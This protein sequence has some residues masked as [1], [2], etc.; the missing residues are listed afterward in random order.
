MRSLP[1][2]RVP[3]LLVLIACGAGPRELPVSPSP[4]LETCCVRSSAGDGLLIQYLGVGGWLFRFGEASLLTAPL[5]SNPGLL[6]VG[7]GRIATDTALVD[8][9]LPPVRD[10]SAILVGHAHYDHLMDVPYIARVKAPGAVV[11]GSRTA[12]NLLQGD[13]ELDPARLVDVESVAG[14]HERP[15]EWIHVADDRIRVMALRSEHAPHFLGLLLFGGEVTEPAQ[16]LPERASGWLAG[17]PLSYLIDFLDPD[18]RVV[19]RIHYQDHA[20]QPPAGLPPPLED[21]V[22]VDLA[23]VTPPGFHEVTGYPEEVVARLRP[24]RVLL[25]HWEDFFRPR[26][27]TTRPVPGTDLE[28]F[29]DR[30]AA[31]LPPG[32]EWSLPEP[33]TVLRILPRTAA[34]A[35]F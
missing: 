7:A 18:G 28:E 24:G 4:V 21:G 35:G 27:R 9:F 23:I 19:Y 26:T 10:V 6:E 13:P 33:G 2:A 16:E 25:G 32:V 31:A 15:G 29:V 17:Q 30:L 5:F 34:G 12:V 3:A 8:R 20:S 1:L 11:Y 14:D 22:P